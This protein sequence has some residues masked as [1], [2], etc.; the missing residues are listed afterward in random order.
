MV[1][2][3]SLLYSWQAKIIARRKVYHY[4][5]ELKMIVTRLNEVVV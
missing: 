5:V 4:F 2:A 1:V 3:I